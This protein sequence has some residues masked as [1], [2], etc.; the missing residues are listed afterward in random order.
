MSVIFRELFVRFLDNTATEIT[1]A[2]ENSGIPTSKLRF[3]VYRSD[4]QESGFTQVSPELTNLWVYRDHYD[5]G[6]PGKYHIWFYKVRAYIAGEPDNYTDSPVEYIHENPMDDSTSP[7]KDPCVDIIRRHNFMLE[8]S[9]YRI[10]K[11]CIIYQKRI[12]GE[13]CD[14]FDKITGRVTSS[15]CSKCLGTGKVEG[16][17]AGIDDI[18]VH[19]VT[20]S[21]AKMLHQ[22][23]DTIPGDSSGWMSNFPIVKPEDIIINKLTNEHWLV[24]QVQPTV[25]LIIVRQN[26]LLRKLNW[27]DIKTLLPFENTKFRM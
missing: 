18:Y 27:D 13:T 6:K 7:F 24:K 3:I 21:K 9:R 20:L 4:H 25:R 2:V 23:G 14:C 1:W 8:H 17:H 26:L 11:P 19:F 22:Y 5:G 12:Y 16:Y 10:G 15:K